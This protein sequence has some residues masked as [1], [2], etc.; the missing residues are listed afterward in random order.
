[1]IKQ[2]FIF[3]TMIFIVCMLT[4]CGD[5]KTIDGFE[6]T[7]YGLIN[8]NSKKNPNIEYRLIW[9]NVVWGCILSETIIAPIYFFGYSTF[10]PVG[11]LSESEKFP[12]GAVRQK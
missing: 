8:E 5:N 11:F 3:I 9:G 1:M 12:K 10:E 2:I 6:Y 4:C 7:T